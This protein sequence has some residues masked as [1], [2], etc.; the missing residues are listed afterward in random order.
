[1]VVVVVV[2][3]IL[4]SSRLRSISSRLVSAGNMRSR[5]VTGGTPGSLEDMIGQY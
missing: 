3:C 5:V 1:M 4:V 2:I